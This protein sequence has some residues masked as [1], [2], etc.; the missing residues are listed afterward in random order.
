[1]FNR[2]LMIKLGSVFKQWI[3]GVSQRTGDYIWIA[4]ADDLCDKTFYKR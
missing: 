4:E 1:M 3:K 2:L